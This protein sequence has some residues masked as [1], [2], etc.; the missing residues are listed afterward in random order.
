MQVVLE[1][2]IP[3]EDLLEWLW[4]RDL[5]NG[6]DY[7]LKGMVTHPETYQSMVKIVEFTTDDEVVTEFC[8]RW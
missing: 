7:E 4:A 1:K 8:L 3:V 5:R 2:A 6:V